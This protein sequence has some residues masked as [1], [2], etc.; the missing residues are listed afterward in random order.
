[1]FQKRKTGFTLIEL[2]VVIAIIALLVGILLPAL[3]RAR[4]NA[5]KVK[6]AANVRSLLQSL[7]SWAPDNKGK[8]P[9]PSIADRNNDVI[10]GLADPGEKNTTGAM[11]SLMIYQNSITPEILFSPADS[12]SVQVDATYEYS[13][14]DGT[15]EPF[16]AAYD[17]SFKGT[18][19]DHN[20]TY[21]DVEGM[22]DA[23]ISNNS[24]A[25]S[26]IAGAR[27]ARWSDTFSSSQV[28]AGTRG[29]VYQTFGTTPPEVGTSWEL[30]AGAIGQDSETLSFFGQPNLWAG[31]VGFAD[32]HVEYADRPDPESATVTIRDGENVYSVNDN[33]FV[34]EEYEGSMAPVENRTN[35]V[36]RQFFAGVP[37]NVP[38]NDQVL[39]GDAAAGIDGGSAY[40]FVEGNPV[41]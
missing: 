34:D 35:A 17:P 27:R 12:G 39:G 1:M 14:P 29:P 21:G 7:N 3:S 11:L 25:H 9:T 6:D 26:P 31:N 19:N 22:I 23:A 4:K 40:T 2:L 30:A 38:F 10:S 32:A 37:F 5:I 13:E 18:P 8:F 36:I 24:Y 33:I 28:V 20:G 15:V 41:N 16:R